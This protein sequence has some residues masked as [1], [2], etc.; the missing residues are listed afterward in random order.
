MLKELIYEYFDNERKHKEE[1]DKKYLDSD[2]KF[3]IAPSYLT[4]CIRK[5]WYKKTKTIQS[6]PVSLHSYIKFSMGDAIHEKLAE[7]LS[8][9]AYIK[10]GEVWHDKEIH[11]IEWIYRVDNYILLKSNEFI[12]EIKS[13]YGNTAYNDLPKENAIMQLFCYLLLEKINQGILLY[14]CRDTGFIEEFHFSIE[15]LKEKYGNKYKERLSKLKSIRD[16]IE[17]IPNREYNINLKNLNG[18][19]KTDFQKDGIKYKSDWQCLYCQWYNECW[20]KEL[21][22]IKNHKF[23]IDGTFYD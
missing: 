4:D 9:V 3:N 15:G 18:E 12:I 22:K 14:L 7:I 17:Q 23:Y 11:G 19:I 10:K 20:E 8:K 6:N 13:I 16:N 21:K 2:K 1:R 5:I